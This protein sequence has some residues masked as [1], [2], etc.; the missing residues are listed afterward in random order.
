[1]FS[2]DGKVLSYHHDTIRRLH[3]T[4]R[5]VFIIQAT[6]DIRKHDIEVADLC[7]AYCVKSLSGFDFSA[8]SIGLKTICEQEPVVDVFVMNDSVYGPFS[9]LWGRALKLNWDFVGFTENM[10]LTRHIQSYAFFCFKLTKEKLLGMG[11]LFDPA[12]CFDGYEDTVYMKELPMARAMHRVGPTGS[13]WGLRHDTEKSLKSNIVDATISNR[14]PRR[15]IELGFPFMKKR[16]PNTEW[17]TPDERA[18]A[19]DF[20]QSAGITRFD[21]C[22]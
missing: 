3:S 9:D 1:L 16:V 4:G 5:K 22:D 8:Y 14:Y 13:L 10:A 2:P 17:L 20:L 15:L 18:W 21:Q 11:S 6:P 12:A 19:I 7:D